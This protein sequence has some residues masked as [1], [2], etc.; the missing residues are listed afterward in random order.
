[1]KRYL[2]EI[3]IIVIISSSYGFATYQRN[4]IWQDDF[5]LWQDVVNKSAHKPRGHNNLGT[6]LSDKGLVAEAIAEYETSILLKSC[7]IEPRVNL[8]S[9][10]SAIG[11]TDKAIAK[12][13]Q[14]L[15]L[16]PG[17]PHIHYNLGLA[18]SSKGLYDQAIKEFEETLRLNPYD[19]DACQKLKTLRKQTR[20]PSK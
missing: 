13:K 12:F 3:L 11:M 1:M 2:I 9:S 15:I 4:V 18:Y 19:H 5:S 17:N 7:Q 8:A 6:V 14:I 20:Q 16:V 10:Y